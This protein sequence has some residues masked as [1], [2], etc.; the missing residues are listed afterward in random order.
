MPICI[1]RMN[2]LEEDLR[3]KAEKVKIIDFAVNRLLKKYP[4]TETVLD[5]LKSELNS[6]NAIIQ[7]LR[8]HKTELAKELQEFQEKERKGTI[9]KCIKLTTGLNS[10]KTEIKSLEKKGIDRVSFLATEEV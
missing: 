2:S 6:I 3:T 9:E 10:K 8:S 4:E 5:K 1:G 7:K